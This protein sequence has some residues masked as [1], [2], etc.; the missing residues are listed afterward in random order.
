MRPRGILKRGI[1]HVSKQVIFLGAE[2]TGDSSILVEDT[3]DSSILVD[4][5]EDSS[6]LVE[7]T[8]DS[9]ILVEDTGDSSILVEDTED[10]SILAEDTGDEDSEDSFILA[11]DTVTNPIYN[12]IC[13][14]TVC[15]EWL[16]Y[17][18]PR[19]LCRKTYCENQF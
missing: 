9:S 4:D 5:T 16:G 13:R 11:E 1:H 15:G 17:Q 14:C 10:S 6:I 8:E 12:D 18:N 7:D 3:G 19:Q 2:D